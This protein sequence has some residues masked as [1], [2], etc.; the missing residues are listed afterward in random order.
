MCA[1]G[2]AQDCCAR[3][4]Q[5]EVALRVLCDTGRARGERGAAALQDDR[6]RA[7][8]TEKVPPPPQKKGCGQKMSISLETVSNLELGS[9]KNETV[10]S[11]MLIF[12]PQPVFF[13]FFWNFLLAPGAS[14]PTAESRDPHRIHPAPSVS[15]R[16]RQSRQRF[17]WHLK[18]SRV[19][20][21]RRVAARGPK[22]AVGRLPDRWELKVLTKRSK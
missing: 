12:C 21:S 15:P 6:R 19:R 8:G 17:F 14:S 18:R 16:Q 22:P 3:R 10:S 7:P 5:C 2:G 1:G 11:E 4:A 20:P 9:A 13:F